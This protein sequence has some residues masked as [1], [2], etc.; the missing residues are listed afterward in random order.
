MRADSSD[1]GARFAIAALLLLLAASARAQSLTCPKPGEWP[2][3]LRLEYDVTASRGPFSINGESILAFERNGSA[4]SVTVDT[5]SALIYHA[6]QTSRGTIDASGLRPLEFVETRGS[7]T[8]QTAKFDWDAKLVHFSAAADSPAP[9]EPGLQDRVS[10]LLQLALQVRP[11]A[12]EGPL[13]IPVAGARR[14]GPYRFA[15]RGAETVKVPIG[16]MEALHLERTPE[17]GDKDRLEAWFAAGW[18]GL[19]VRLRFTDRNGSVV[20]ERLRAARID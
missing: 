5:E 1:R 9:T 13:E 18:C 12:R 17:E 8:P 4:Y 16:T 7:R 10:V 20:D 14:V 15:K 3:K 19:P 6:R 11:A 2:A